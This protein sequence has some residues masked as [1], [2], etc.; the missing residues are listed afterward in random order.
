MLVSPGGILAD[1]GTDHALLPVWLLEKGRI[2]GAIAMDVNEGPLSRAR[3][4]IGAAGLEERISVRLSDGFE[5]LGKGEADSAVIAGMGGDLMIR[6]LEEGME[7]AS[8]LKEII[9][10]PQSEIA[11]VRSF[12]RASGFVIDAEDM[13]LEDGKYYQMF[14]LVRGSC[15]TCPPPGSDGVPADLADLYGPL[16]LEQGHPVLLQYLDWEKGIREQILEQLQNSHGESREARCALIREELRANERAREIAAGKKA[17][18][19]I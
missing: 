7:V 5:A 2:R 15:Q 16:L 4:S 13:V 1:I 11:R 6:I 3:E 14:R 9:C 19:G 8:S 17:C 12:A 18:P 10:S